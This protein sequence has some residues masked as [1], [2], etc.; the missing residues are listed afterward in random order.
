MYYSDHLTLTILARMD[1]T[2]L[3]MDKPRANKPQSI[4]SIQKEVAQEKL[5]KQ[6]TRAR[7]RKMFAQ[8]KLQKQRKRARVGT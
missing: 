7:T 5:P 2:I 3:R 1:N 4:Q 6:R 8:E